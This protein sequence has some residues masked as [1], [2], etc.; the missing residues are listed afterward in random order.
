MKNSGNEN[1]KV[2]SHWSEV[3]KKSQQTQNLRLRWWQSPYIIR[4]INKKVT[5]SPLDGFSQGITQRAKELAG[6]RYPF[7]RGISVGCGNGQKE[8]TLVRQGLVSSFQ[9]YELS[10]VRIDQG[11][12]LAAKFGVENKVSLFKEML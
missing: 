8:I 12:R 4:H 1:K 9:L 3:T 7:S 2:A 6:D 10:A 5:G 11:R